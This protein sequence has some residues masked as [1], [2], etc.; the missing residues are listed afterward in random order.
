MSGIKV[1]VIVPVGNPGPYIS[2]CVDSLMHQTLTDIEIIF[3]DDCGV[4]GSMDYVLS[5]AK[6]DSRVQIIKNEKNIGAGP[7]RNKGIQRAVGEYLSFVDADDF[8]EYDFLE[9]L[10]RKAKENNSD[11]AKGSYDVRLNHG[12]NELCMEGLNINSSIQKSLTE[13]TPL[14]NSFYATHWSA[15][16]HA[17]LF[18]ESDVYYGE[19]A[20]SEDSL[21]LLRVCAHAR[22]L[23]IVQEARYH[24]VLRQDS[25]SNRM[26]ESTLSEYG[27]GLHA[28]METLVK[29]YAPDQYAIDYAAKKFRFYIYQHFQASLVPELE[30]AAIEFLNLI[31]NEVLILPFSK[32]L[33]E[34]DPAIRILVECGVALPTYYSLRSRNPDTEL[35]YGI[36]SVNRWIDFL[37]QYPDYYHL[38]EDQL[39]GILCTRPVLYKK[40]LKRKKGLF[41]AF[42]PSVLKE[43][44]RLPF[45]DYLRLSNKLIW[46]RIPAHLIR[47]G[48]SFLS[49]RF[50]PSFDIRSRT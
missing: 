29:T 50:G 27:R 42:Y 33:I 49:R 39:L 7:S 20:V 3:V 23:V 46:T 45:K 2:R 44:C 22:S 32:E 28:L 19:T 8:V 17:S 30:Q 21:F 26:T 41:L 14:M 34:R 6:E 5:A 10:Y 13:R 47:N 15:I 16:Y 9:S 24:Y 31:R 18:K 37:I 4:D 35:Q 48:C 40:P 25:S 36:A 12:T 38:C 43:L 1:S 11:I